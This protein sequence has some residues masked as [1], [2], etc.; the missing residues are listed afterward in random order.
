MVLYEVSVEL[1]VCNFVL[2]NEF[3]DAEFGTLN[4]RDLRY[5]MRQYGVTINLASKYILMTFKL[6][7][8]NFEELA[9]HN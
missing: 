8:K 6:Y 4:I 9:N 7:K 3:N 1:L 5:N 2:T